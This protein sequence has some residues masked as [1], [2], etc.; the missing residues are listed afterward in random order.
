[1]KQTENK[2][3]EALNEEQQTHESALSKQSAKEQNNDEIEVKHSFKLG[4]SFL[5]W[6]GVS[7]LAVGLVMVILKGMKMPKPH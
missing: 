3:K 7:L 1:M 5:I 2:R 4:I 6:V